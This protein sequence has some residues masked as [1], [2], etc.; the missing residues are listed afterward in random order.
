MRP[1]AASS[2]TNRAGPP[3]VEGWFDTGAGALSA[4]GARALAAN[5]VGAWAANDAGTL[6]A[7]DVG[8]L[9][10]KGARALAG[11]R[12][13]A[14]HPGGVD[15]APDASPTSHHKDRRRLT[16][17]TQHAPDCFCNARAAG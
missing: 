5:D 12:T 17:P 3:S 15:K 1:T 9:A 16:P 2:V 14:V 11:G 10:A 4:A 13:G 7:S 6:A 8:A